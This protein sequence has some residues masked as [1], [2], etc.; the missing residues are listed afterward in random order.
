MTKQLL[1]DNM[2]QKASVWLLNRL[3]S[4]GVKLSSSLNLQYDP[5]GKADDIVD[6]KMIEF[7]CSLIKS[8][9][10]NAL[11]TDIFITLSESEVTFIGSRMA[12]IQAVVRTGV[13]F[14][15]AE[16]DPFG[17]DSHPT[18]AFNICFYDGEIV[19]SE[20]MTCD[21]WHRRSTVVND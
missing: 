4:K 8:P 13:F 6:S 17:C 12:G 1:T 20:F 3:D 9:Q 21:D 5:A 10:D 2:L 11:L 19:E 15:G 16:S 18:F 7:D 14:T